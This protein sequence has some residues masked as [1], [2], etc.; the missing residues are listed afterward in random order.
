A[1]ADQARA[2][3]G[4]VVLTAVLTLA[5][6]I[7][8]SYAAADRMAAVLGRAGRQIASRIAAFLLLGIGVQIMLSGIIPVLHDA[9]GS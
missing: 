9:L 2:L 3:L 5:V 8:A 7:W 6:M 1:A 4:Y